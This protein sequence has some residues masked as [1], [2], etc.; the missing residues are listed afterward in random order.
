M[1]CVPQSGMCDRVELCSSDADCPPDRFCGERGTCQPGCESDISCPGDLLCQGIRCAPA[2]GP[3]NPCP[4]G[5][6]CENDGHCRVPGGCVTSAECME[7]ETYCDREQ[8]RCVPGCEVGHDCLMQR[9][10]AWVAHAGPA[11]VAETFTP[12]QISQQDTNMCTDAPG[13]HCEA[14][15]DPSLMPHV[16]GRVVGVC[17]SKTMRAMRSAISASKPASRSPM[18]APRGIPVLN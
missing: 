1:A 10:S 9:W 11:V 15:C 5:Q 13:S 7:R 16:G 18:S 14:G 4:E 12:G 8:L 6:M 3:E 17:P 2:C